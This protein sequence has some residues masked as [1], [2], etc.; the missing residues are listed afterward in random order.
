MIKTT[1]YSFSSKN[2]KNFCAALYAYASNRVP[3]NLPG[4]VPCRKRLRGPCRAGIF[5]ASGRFHRLCTGAAPAAP[6]FASTRCNGTSK[7]GVAHARRMNQLKEGLKGTD[8]RCSFNTHV[9]PL[10]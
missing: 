5:P 2:F 8:I 9:I 6:A 10:L 1:M 7:T 4:P 3:R